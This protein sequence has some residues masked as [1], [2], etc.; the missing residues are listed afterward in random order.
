VGASG[1]TEFGGTVL[2]D[3]AATVFD[4]AKPAPDPFRRERRF[5]VDEGVKRKSV[6]VLSA[7]VLQA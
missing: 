1:R 2:V 6:G 7:S 5:A 3:S 4:P